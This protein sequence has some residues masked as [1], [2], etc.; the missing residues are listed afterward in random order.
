[1]SSISFIILSYNQC[2]NIIKII[3]SIVYSKIDYELII[4]DNN[5]TDN[6]SEKISNFCNSK[7]ISY[8]F[9]NNPIQKNQ[10]LSRNIGVKNATKEYIYFVDGD[11]YLNS[12]FLNKM[13]LNTDIVFIPRIAKDLDDD[14]YSININDIE[15]QILYSSAVQGFYKKDILIKYNIW[16]EE[17]KYFYYSEDLLF[18]ALLF[19]KI[20]SDRLQYSYIKNDYLYFGIKRETSTPIDKNDDMKKYYDDFYRYLIQKMNTVT[21][22]VFVMDKINNLIKELQQG[23]LCQN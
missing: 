11:D 18:T 5:S 17:N 15:N 4:I 23:E 8:K 12:Y 3:N 16:H 20:I 22:F 14:E 7:N 13:E 2:D 9:I 1:M 21:G 6:T 10:S 19:D